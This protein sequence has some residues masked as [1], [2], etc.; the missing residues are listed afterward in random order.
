MSFDIRIKDYDN[1]MEEYQLRRV[2]GRNGQICTF[3]C[4]NISFTTVQVHRGHKAD[5]IAQEC[6]GHKIEGGNSQVYCGPIT[7][8]V[9][10]SEQPRPWVL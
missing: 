5:M 4:S 9:S 6:L 8:T 3:A 10:T 7:V 1:P 2:H